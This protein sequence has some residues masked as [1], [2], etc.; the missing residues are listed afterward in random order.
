MSFQNKHASLSQPR[1]I[2][3]WLELLA[4]LLFMLAAMGPQCDEQEPND[5]TATANLLRPGEY[6][7]GAV[8]PSGEPDVFITQPLVTNDEIYAYVDPRDSGT[9]QDT[10]LD[11][12]APDGVTLIASDNDSGPTPVQ[13]ASAVAGLPLPPGP[14]GPVYFRITENGNDSTVTSYRFYQAIVNRSNGVIE[15]EPNNTALTA[16]TLSGD[17][18]GGAAADGTGDVDFFRFTVRTANARVVVIMDDNPTDAGG[19]TDTELRLVDQDGTTFLATGDDGGANRA[20]ASGAETIAAPGTYYVRVAN[21]NATSGDF[22]EFVLLINGVL[23][24]DSDADGIPDP[25]DNCPTTFN[26]TQQDFDLDGVGDL[27]DACSLDILKTA[28]GACGCGQPDVDI[29]GDGVA[30]CGLADP[31]RAMLASAGLLLVTDS[32]ND[33][34]M[35]FDPFD[36]EL[37]DPNFIPPDA[38]NLATPIA[39]ILGPDRNSILVSDLTRDAVQRYDLDGNYLGIFAPAGGVNTAIIDQPTGIAYRSNGNLLVCV[40]SGANAH[41]VA[42]FDAAGNHIANFIANG[43]GGLVAPTD[44]QVLPDGQARV[45]SAGSSRI[46]SFD[47]AGA[48]VA[49]FA[50]LDN[51]MGQI[52]LA[53]NGNLFAGCGDL[54]FRGVLEFDP[55]GTLVRRRSPSR[56]NGF[57]GIAELRSSALF[58]T[59][60]SLIVTGGA[61]GRVAGGAFVHSRGGETITPRFLGAN[62]R[63]A[64]FVQ[65]DADGDGTGDSVDGCPNDAAKTSPGQCGCGVADI[66]TDGDAVADCADG[67]PADIA[68]IAPG[69]CGCGIP[70]TDANANGTPDCLDTIPPPAPATAAGCCAPGMATSVGLVVP[71]VLVSWKLRRRAQL[72]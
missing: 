23:Y 25:D 63:H 64:E 19:F 56:F 72:T 17:F 27:C 53:Q 13:F 67:C 20:N 59:A 2:R 5:N 11:V 9:S 8:N 35:A 45:T 57:T 65:I 12:L 1:H 14:E 60:E 62:L 10:F 28:P 50:T 39:A 7:T 42:E 37:V 51:D 32:D 26:P 3:K 69:A 31:A 34:V 68:K 33:R 48:F 38:V 36:G 55:A 44:I 6:G 15:V 54:A 66:D 22:Y 16:N 52:T 70:D 71:M 24:R 30:D 41:A 47:Q 40:Q 21:G 4:L 49:E 58:C 61:D 29:N 43:A 46:L 18:M